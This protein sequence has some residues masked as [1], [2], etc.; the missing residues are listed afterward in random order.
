[1]GVDEG[2]VL[3]IGEQ[4][5][6]HVQLAKPCVLQPLNPILPRSTLGLVRSQFSGEALTLRCRKDISAHGA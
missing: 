1:M 2:V 6:V 3:A 5:L 4:A